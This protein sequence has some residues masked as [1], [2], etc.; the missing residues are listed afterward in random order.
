[1]TI[2]FYHNNNNYN[3]KVTKYSNRETENINNYNKKIDTACNNGFKVL[4]L[5]SDASLEENLKISK[6]F[7]IKNIKKLC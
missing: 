2:Q 1:M 6:D 7:I 3:S 5:W 4:T